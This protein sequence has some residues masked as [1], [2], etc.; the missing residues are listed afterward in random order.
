MEKFMKTI[1]LTLL[2]VM[3]LGVSCSSGK[4]GVAKD[5][6]AKAK[7][8]NSDFIV[9][10]DEEDLFLEDDK[11]GEVQEQQQST[12]NAEESVAVEEA[13]AEENLDSTSVPVVDTGACETVSYTVKKGETLMQ[14]AFKLYGDYRKWKELADM[15][16]GLDVE[17]LKE[18]TAISYCGG[19]ELTWQPQ[20]NPY[21]IRTGDTLG[22]IS[23]DKYGT[24]KRWKDIWDNNRPLIHD[25]NKIFAGF[26][27]YYIPDEVANL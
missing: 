8:E 2:V 18:G 11:G 27:I 3:L 22:S 13:P 26:T 21:V 23:N 12:P 1:W 9:D 10:S 15:N 4:K 6:D 20:G 14:I 17:R 25:P 24:I 16:Q 7:L 19:H 5:G